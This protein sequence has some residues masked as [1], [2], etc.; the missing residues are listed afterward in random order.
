MKLILFLTL[1]AGIAIAQNPHMKSVSGGKIKQSLL[2]DGK[3]FILKFVDQNRVVDLNEYYPENEEPETWTRMVSVSF[4]KTPLSPGAMAQNMER[5][6]LQ[7]HPDAP[8]QLTAAP[9]GST[10]LFMCVNWVRDRNTESEFSVFRFQKRP[11]GVLG[12]Q[13]SLRPYQAKISMADFNALKDRW[14]KKIQAGDW[15]AVTLQMP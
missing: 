12:Y 3:T 14:A 1:L 8:H 10:A 15:P 13:A 7:K 2:F 6:L 9:D 11:N 4:Y 5:G